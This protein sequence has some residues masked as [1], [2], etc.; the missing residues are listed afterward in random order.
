MV[1]YGKVWYGILWYGMVLYGMVWYISILYI[2]CPETPA[3]PGRAG[4][5]MMHFTCLKLGNWGG[6]L[7]SLSIPVLMCWFYSPTFLDVLKSSVVP[8]HP[9]N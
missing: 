8:Q 6:K 3:W 4:L 5:L 7:P 9:Y 1:W 2:I